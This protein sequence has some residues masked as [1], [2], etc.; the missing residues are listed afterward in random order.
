VEENNTYT[1]TGTHHIKARSE[2]E[3]IDKFHSANPIE[4]IYTVSE[5]RQLFYDST[6][7]G[8]DPLTSKQKVLQKAHK[9]RWI[10]AGLVLFA[11]LFTLID[12][13]F[14]LR[15]QPSIESEICYI[16]CGMGITLIELIN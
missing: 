15:T 1:V 3:A 12:R 4:G 2:T 10:S 9:N 11:V 7:A 13:D 6:K 16:F 14:F 5:H 8:K